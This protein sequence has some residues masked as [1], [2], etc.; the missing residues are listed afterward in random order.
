MSIELLQTMEWSKLCW[1]LSFEK[2]IELDL[3]LPKAGN[4][5]SVRF[6]KN[7][8][9]AK[10]GQAFLLWQPPHLELN[11]W[12]D[13]RPS[14]ILRSYVLEGVLRNTSHDDLIFDF[15]VI[16]RTKLVNYFSKVNETKASPLSYIGQPNGSSILQ[17]RDARGLIKSN[18]GQYLYL[19]G[20][21][22]ETSLDAILSYEGNRLCLH[23]SATLHFPAHYQTIVTKYY[24]S[25]DEHIAFDQLLS[26]AEEIIDESMLNLDHRKIKGAEYW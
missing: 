6:S 20:S 18:I 2:L 21:E 14:E 23:Y 3:I 1:D 7:E 15:D 13:K 8:D 16:S 10:E 5:Y 24:L 11:G 12:N 25:K 9:Y 17:W 22:C 19:S 4:T 26:Q